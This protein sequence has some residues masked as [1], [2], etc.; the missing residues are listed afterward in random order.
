MTDE[1][2]AK[3]RRKISTILIVCVLLFSTAILFGDFM[4]YKME[5]ALTMYLYFLSFVASHEGIN[6]VTPAGGFKR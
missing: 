2:K 1:L 6:M 5:H 3:R 4:G